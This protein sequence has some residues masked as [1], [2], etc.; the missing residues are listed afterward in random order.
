MYHVLIWLFAALNSLA[1]VHDFGQV[2]GRKVYYVLIAISYL[3]A[4]LSGA[5]YD[6]RNKMHR[7]SLRGVAMLC[8]SNIL[9]E[10]FF[11][12]LQL[13]WNEV[14]FAAEIILYEF[15]VFGY[16]YN[17]IKTKYSSGKNK[18]NKG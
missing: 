17:L 13:S 16:I 6:K 7:R 18:L 1:G 14:F 3:P 5:F 12:P 9:D 10:V 2:C 11:N 4:V 15:G 8:I